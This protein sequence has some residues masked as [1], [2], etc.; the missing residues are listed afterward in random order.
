MAWIEISFDNF[1]NIFFPSSLKHI[2]WLMSLGS[3]QIPSSYCMWLLH[4]T[5]IVGS[6]TEYFF[7]Y[8][9]NTQAMCYCFIHFV[10]SKFYSKS[11]SLIISHKN[12]VKC[13]LFLRFCSTYFKRSV[14]GIPNYG[15]NFKHSFTILYTQFLRHFILTDHS[16]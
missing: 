13:R 14:L 7:K 5:P 6:L 9:L 2:V 1:N 15:F 16:S 4:L 3:Y 8:S 11:S 12:F 10:S